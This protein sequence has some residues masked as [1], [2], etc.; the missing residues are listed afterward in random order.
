MREGHKS[1]PL[2]KELN[3][4]GK[5]D[6]QIARIQKGLGCSYEEAVEV[7]NDDCRIDKGEKL[8]EL[9][10]EQEKAS[11]KARGT[12]TKAKQPTAYKFTQQPTRKK[13]SFFILT[14]IALFPFS[15]LIII[16]AEH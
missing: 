10:K 5:A 11:K 12:G 8:F 6:E 3:P 16:F 4:M 9:T 13:T 1:F 7:Y 15:T 2:R 14:N